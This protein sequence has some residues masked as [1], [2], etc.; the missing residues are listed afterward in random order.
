MR[1]SMR[2]SMRPKVGPVQAD[3]LCRRGLRGVP[4]GGGGQA[5]MTALGT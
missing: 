1:A 4:A 3:G 2:L 5:G